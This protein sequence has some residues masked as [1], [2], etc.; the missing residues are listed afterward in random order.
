MAEMLTER[1]V[2]VEE[3]ERKL[4]AGLS[5]DT[6][7]GSQAGRRPADGDRGGRQ[8]CGARPA[9]GPPAGAATT[10]IPAR[11]SPVAGQAGAGVWSNTP[12]D[13]A[14]G[15]ED[16]S[17]RLEAAEQELAASKLRGSGNASP[18]VEDMIERQ[19]QIL[20]KLT[21]R[22]EHTRTSTIRVEPRITWPKLGDDGPGGKE[23]E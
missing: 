20:E 6:P 10:S 2:S 12:P 7:E 4:T 18:M 1:G 14:T 11:P 9:T 21:N 13:S 22:A 8:P 16:L 3:L 19:T 5:I 15:V 17:R 23:V